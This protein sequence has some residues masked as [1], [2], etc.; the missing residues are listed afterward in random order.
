MPEGP[1]IFAY[2]YKLQCLKGEY[3]KSIFC[4]SDTIKNL[5]VG[6]E[7]CD[8]SSYGKYFILSTPHYFLTVHLGMEGAITLNKKLNDTATLMLVTPTYELNIYQARIKIQEGKPEEYF[9]R[10]TDIMSEEYD[11][12]RVLQRLN[13]KKY[14]NKEIGDA[15]MDQDIFTGVGNI[16]RNEVLFRCKIHP[17]SLVNQLS[18]NQLNK[19]ASECSVYGFIF[20]KR[21]LEGTLYTKTDV[22]KKHV[23]PIHK[24]PLTVYVGGKVKRH[25]FVCETCQKL[26]S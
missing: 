23:C 6:N 1:T 18:L 14:A 11:T 12:Q 15:L 8:I 26:Y 4:A 7:I 22:Y 25:T 5:L 20:F 24:T 13:S 9:D 10:R 17:Q 2:R 19:L 3:I 21:L 16:I